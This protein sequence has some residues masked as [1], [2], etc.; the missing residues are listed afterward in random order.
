MNPVAP[1][2]SFS[3]GPRSLST[4]SL[5]SAFISPVPTETSMLSDDFLDLNP[6]I[7]DLGPDGWTVLVSG[8]Y[9]DMN[10]KSLYLRY[11]LVRARKQ[12][13]NVDDQPLGSLGPDE[14]QFVG[15]KEYLAI[16]APEIDP[17]LDDQRLE[18][19]VMCITQRLEPGTLP[20]RIRRCP[21]WYP[22]LLQQK[23]G[24]AP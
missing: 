12:V 11:A 1:L 9:W 19:A 16:M 21:Q 22:K 8:N 3:S 2:F 20:T 6:E 14:L 7:R 15:P 4:S 10:E 24:S 18:E 17:K 13:V 5:V 23:S